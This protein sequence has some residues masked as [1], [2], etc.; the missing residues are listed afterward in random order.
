MES[1]KLNR[2]D[3]LRLSA[4][5]ATGAVVAACAPATPIIIEKEVI[6]EVPVEKA[7][8]VEK[9]VVKEVIKEVAVEKVVKE[10]VV[11]EKVVE[12]A[13]KPEPATIGFWFGWTPE[14][15]VKTMEAV[16]RR[17]EELNPEIKV[18]TLPGG[19]RGEKLMTA[20]AAGTPPD[21][22]EIGR[23]PAEFAVRGRVRPLDDWIDASD[24]ITEDLFW[25][26]AW[27]LMTWQGTR[28]SV[29]SLAFHTEGALIVNGQVYRN[30]GLEAPDDVPRTWDDMYEQ[31]VEYTEIDDSG[32]IQLLWYEPSRDLWMGYTRTFSWG[33]TPFDGDTLTFN[34]DNP[35]YV[36]YINSI[37][38]FFEHLGVER[39]E[40]FRESYPSW[41][42]IPGAAFPSN[43]QALLTSGYW[44]P[45][46]MEKIAPD[47]E[48]YYMFPPVSKYRE[49]EKLITLTG[50]STGIPV[51]SKQPH[52]AWE[53]IQFLCTIEAHDIIYR[54]TGFV[55]PARTFHEVMDVDLYKGQDFF[56]K[57]LSEADEIE[58]EPPCPIRSM[59]GAEG[60]KAMESVIFGEKT[61]EEALADLQELLTKE[62]RRVLTR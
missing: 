25:P 32:N 21:V 28:Y 51:D 26:E 48:F 56:V 16:A 47:G 59:V 18:T 39:V 57:A 53:F 9:E 8:I 33:L 2:R 50:H 58:S 20:F 11:V 7:V 14:I 49:G 43:R 54:G 29:P 35:R 34:Y 36:E 1:R 62:I 6:K 17:F 60:V 24:I 42:A 46:E 15:H 22:L 41:V 44:I 13:P 30:V 3:F 38:Q 45:G 61:A 27:N 55:G 12:V 10:T 4:A 52:A 19:S 5:A 40:A 23:G 37:V 31:T